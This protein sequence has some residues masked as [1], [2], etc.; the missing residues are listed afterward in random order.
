MAVAQRRPVLLWGDPGTGKSA[1]VRDLAESTNLPVEV[2]VASLRE[3]ADFAGLPVVDPSGHVQLAPPAWGVRL[4]EAG[5]GILFLDEISTAPPAVQAALLRVVLERV[6]GDLTL[7]P[8][9]AIVA[10]ANP[11]E[12]AAG[13]W[14][15]TAPL[16]NRF[17]HLDWPVDPTGYV[18]SLAGGWP[19]VMVAQDTGDRVRVAGVKGVVAGFLRARPALVLAVPGDVTGAGR[20]WPS[21]RSWDAAIDLWAAA[22]RCNVSLDAQLALL[23]GCVGPGV[24]RELLTWSQELDLPDPEVILSDPSRFRLPDR[25]DRQFAVLSAITAAVS[26]DP[27]P[28]RWE[29][30]FGLIE[31]AVNRG[32]ADIA[33]VAARTL[34]ECA[35]AGLEALPASLTAL[36]PV[37]GRAGLLKRRSSA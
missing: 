30:A 14:E 2:V 9:V 23:A 25:G 10:A 19:T 36:A 20:A 8:D 22:L 11:T 16:A 37:L 18:E 7:P 29:A 3:P 4:A 1:I 31:Q 17:C 32:A 26:A 27:T 24:A 33:A 15:I 28:A 35:P 21:P 6:V 12:S 13:G 34:A 5:T